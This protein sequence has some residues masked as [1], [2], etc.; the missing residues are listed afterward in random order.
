[1]MLRKL[2]ARLALAAFIGALSVGVGCAQIDSLDKK[3][4]QLFDEL[5]KPAGSSSSSSHSTAKRKPKCSGLSVVERDA[6]PRRFVTDANGHD[7]P[8][9]GQSS[10][11]STTPGHD[12][13]METEAEKMARSGKYAYV[14]MR[15]A[16]GHRPGEREPTHPG[17]HRRALQR[18]GGCVRGQIQF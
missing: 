8:I 6:M 18:P 2:L 5:N 11:S 14:T 3:T 4:D 12:T 17:Y 10:S 1:M 16:H 15:L 7:V 13:T 9:W